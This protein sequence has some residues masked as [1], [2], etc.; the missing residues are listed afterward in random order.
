[1]RLIDRMR[2]VLVRLIDRMRL[3]DRMRLVLVRL[4][5]KMRL[6]LAVRLIHR[7]RLILRLH[8]AGLHPPL[9]AAR[10]GRLRGR[11]WGVG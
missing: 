7:M 9:G 8:L 11:V 2:L 1:M 10:L 5:D 3:S 6:I 4:I